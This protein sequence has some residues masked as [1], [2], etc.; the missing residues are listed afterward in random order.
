MWTGN[1]AEQ[2]PGGNSSQPEE[3]PFPGMAIATEGLAPFPISED[4]TISGTTPVRA[5]CLAI[6]SGSNKVQAAW[7]W[8]SFLSANQD[9]VSNGRTEAA[10]LAQVPARKSVAEATG[11]WEQLPEGVEPVLRYAVEHAWTGGFYPQSFN[12]VE[13]ALS[14]ALLE[15]TDFT[16]AFFEARAE[17]EDLPPSTPDSIAV[18]TPR[19]TRDVFSEVTDIRF[20][21]S[22]SSLEEDQAIR[23]SVEAFNQEHPD[24]NVQLST[25]L[26]LPSD[27]V[28]DLR[29][30][31]DENYDCYNSAAS[32]WSQKPE[33]LL[34]LNTLIQA[35]EEA[36]LQD[37]LPEQ[38]A[39]YYFEGELYGLPAASQPRL[40]SYNK[41]LLAK[42]GLMPPSAEWTFDDFIQLASAA[43]SR[44]ESDPSY[45]F[46]Y[47]PW[48]DFLFDGRGIEWADWTT[49]P[50]QPLFN[51][52]E[53]IKTLEW[54]SGLNEDGVL[55]NQN[56]E[57]FE[58]VNRA[59]MSGQIA[60][61]ISQAGRDDMLSIT[62]GGNPPYETGV[63]PM[64][65]VEGGKSIT[66]AVNR[67]FFI[68]SRAKNPQACWTLIKYISEQP[69]VYPGVPARRSI[70]ESPAWEALVGEENAIVYRLA[71]AREQTNESSIEN[72]LISRPYHDWKR[73]AI[74][75]ALNG[76]DAVQTLI[77]AQ[78]KADAYLACLA[79]DDGSRLNDP[80]Y[81]D[82]VAACIEQVAPI[83]N[84]P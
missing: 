79:M 46:L 38:L 1:L 25:D 16:S 40:M 52:Q 70:S 67:V 14:I 42:R 61:W 15:G 54:M 12:A 47:T 77:E 73:E 36:F 72:S 80:E 21:S 82:R 13:K 2:M 68:S 55:L 30:Y 26:D 81:Q 32:G 74:L 59:M 64:P 71:L 22:I 49:E 45:G 50:P 57:N 29:A 33:N 4:G 19:P 66:Q 10:S 7:T 31:L 62:T 3:N 6:S 43:A 56:G 23:A 9:F 24:I 35:E 5:Q 37:Y 20:F 11:Y 84:M 18:A 69:G 53:V 51:R 41:D 65:R 17:F 44:S 27:G 48:E 63:V 28:E 78:S 58:E 34:S 39:I 83:G 8:I 60:F 76:E 75:A